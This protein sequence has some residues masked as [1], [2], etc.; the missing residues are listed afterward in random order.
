MKKMCG[1]MGAA[2]V[3]AIAPVAFADE[4]IV[5]GGFEVQGFGSL[6]DSANWTELASDAP[7]TFSRRA[8]GPASS[9]IFSHHLS[10]VGA[11]GIGTTG[12]IIQNSIVDGG[13]TSLEGNT[14]VQMTFK[15][16][17]TLGPGGVAFYA[18][19][20]LNSQGAIVAN[21]GLNVITSGTNGLFASFSTS[22]LTVPAFGSAP[23]DA[24]SAFVEI[25]VAAGAFPESTAEAFIDDLVVT[26]TL[27]AG[28]TADFNSDGFLDF[29]DYNDFVECFETAVCPDGQTADFNGDAFVDFFDYSDFVNAF[30][31][32]C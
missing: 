12:I 11:V 22:T 8:E 2:M 3:F 19:R 31:T 7:G 14:T 5:N 20:V 29:F 18:L 17:V 26:G 32:G 16:R 25:S 13:L 10:A 21:T 30:E 15:A 23:N 1:L 28:C 6:T 4:V 27:T 24:F 9:G